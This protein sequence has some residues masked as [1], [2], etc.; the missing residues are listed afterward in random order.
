MGRQ[1]QTA[2]R[3]EVYM[4]GQCPLC[5]WS[6]ERVEPFDR[7]GRIEWLD[8]ND[9][10]VLRR[11]APHTFQEMAAEMHVRRPDGTW[12]KGFEGWVDVLKVL[13]HLRW[14][15]HVLSVW[16]LTVIGPV[17][18]RNIARRRYQLFGIPPPCDPSAACSLHAP[19]N[20]NKPRVR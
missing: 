11:A 19:E 7:D 13:P 15:G 6:R 4:D 1:Q 9:P 18:Y 8:Y 12:T 5:R 16:P 3:I 17:I 20:L 14:L 2:A 10:E